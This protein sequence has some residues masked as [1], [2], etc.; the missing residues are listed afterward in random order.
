QQHLFIRLPGLWFIQ[1]GNW[2]YAREKALPPAAS[3]NPSRLAR[4]TDNGARHYLKVTKWAGDHLFGLSAARFDDSLNYSERIVANDSVINSSGIRTSNTFLGVSHRWSASQSF[5]LESGADLERQQAASGSFAGQVS[6][7]RSALYL[8]AR[9]NLGGLSGAAGIRQEFN[10]TNTPWPLVSLHASHP[11]GDR[12]FLRA[13][14]SNK[15]RLPNLNEKYW[16]PGGNPDLLP[17]TGFGGDLGLTWNGLQDNRFTPH[18]S[19]NLFAQEVNNWIQWL[20]AGTYWSPLNIR[21]VRCQGME[22]EWGS[23]LRLS[24]TQLKT[25]ILYAYTESLDMSRENISERLERQLAYVPL[26]TFRILAAVNHKPFDGSASFGYH[27]KRHT[28]DVHDQ[29]LDLHAYYL[30]DIQFGYQLQ[31]KQS[32]LAIRLKIN[33]LFNASFQ[34]I[35]GYPSPGR[36]FSLMLIYSM[37]KANNQNQ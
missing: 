11:M 26:H 21:E 7:L 16:K 12:L 8:L 14:L 35:R 1:A 27:G 10:G 34:T 25:T 19:I 31:F 22:A 24:D 2:I 9:L 33:N 15:Y 17:E 36:S 29:Y 13:S 5:S 3:S 37:Q 32:G 18:A 4:Q 6:E 23:T 20:P 30:A 28:T